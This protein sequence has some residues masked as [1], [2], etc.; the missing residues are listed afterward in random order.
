MLRRSPRLKCQKYQANS[1]R[2]TDQWGA[3]QEL[4]REDGSPKD[5][6]R[7][8]ALMFAVAHETKTFFSA[9]NLAVFLPGSQYSA[10]NA[11]D[12]DDVRL[13]LMDADDSEDEADLYYAINGSISQ[14]SS[15][16]ACVHAACRSKHRILTTGTWIQTSAGCRLVDSV[17]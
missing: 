7:E 17:A 15:T 6:D 11:A 13:S 9:E 14:C 12:L 10:L 4:A 8:F 16:H 2:N 5:V 1:S 3:M